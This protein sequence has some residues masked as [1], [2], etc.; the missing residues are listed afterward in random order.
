M[1]GIIARRVALILAGLVFVGV[2][3]QVERDRLYTTCLTGSNPYTETIPIEVGSHDPAFFATQN[4]SPEYEWMRSLGFTHVV[5]MFNV[6]TAESCDRGERATVELRSFSIIEEDEETGETL[7]V[8]TVTFGES[9]MHAGTQLEHRLFY[10]EPWF[11]SGVPAE[12]PIIAAVEDSVYW[13][14]ARFVPKAI[15]HGWTTPRVA[16]KPGKRYLVSVEARITGAARLQLGMDYWRGEAAAYNGWS[17]G[18]ETSH[19][20]QAWLSDWHGDTQGEFVTWQ[21]PVFR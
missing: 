13:L 12:Q 2:V 8:A 20:C 21:A 1:F 9:E 17:A 16:T 15:I 4:V 18:C 5:G 7:P 3:T 10:R 11:T 14:N 6:V 19:N